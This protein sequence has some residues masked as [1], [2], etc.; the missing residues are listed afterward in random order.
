MSRLYYSLEFLNENHECTSGDI[1]PKTL[2]YNKAVEIRSHK[3]KFSRDEFVSKGTSGGKGYRKS[4]Y[5]NQIRNYKRGLTEQQFNDFAD[6][7]TW[8]INIHEN[9][10]N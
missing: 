10:G 9:K 5:H 4:I 3:D 1:N 7:L 2:K 8:D 6:Y